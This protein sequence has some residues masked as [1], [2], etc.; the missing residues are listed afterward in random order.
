VTPSTVDFFESV[1]DPS[2]EYSNN[3]SKFKSLLMSLMFLATRTRPDIL[4]E[5]I[6]LSSFALNPGPIV[7][8][9]LQ[10]VVGYL[11]QSPDVGIRFN[12]FEPT[13]T[14]YCD[15]SFGTH[16]NGRSHSGYVIT[17][18]SNS[19]PIL[20]KSTVQKLVSTSSTES[21]LIC[22]VSG[23]KRVIPI[24][25]LISELDLGFN[26][27]VQV[28]EDNTSC[29]HLASG[30]QKLGSSKRL[31]RVRYSFIRELIEAGTIRLAH[32]PTERMLADICTK[33]IGGQPFRSKRDSLLNA[34]SV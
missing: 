16:H 31:F 28:L 27:F 29:I 18:G 22:L 15:A 23:I 1:D 17:F 9:K 25:Q 34:S 24:V 4:K 20:V 8:N 7:M 30:T 6:F 33:P 21:E 13:L 2:G 19:G 5:V 3:S 10:R 14:I 26:D 12:M 32:C 11:R